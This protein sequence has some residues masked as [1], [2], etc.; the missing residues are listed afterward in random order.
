MIAM[1]AHCNKVVRLRNRI[2]ALIAVHPEILDQEISCLFEYS[3][4]EIDDLNLTFL[5]IL[6]A[7]TAAVGM[8]K[9]Q[10][11]LEKP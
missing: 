11:D 10:Q 8:W 2:L 1:P 3:E 9:A 7:F 4:F 6:Q 5:E